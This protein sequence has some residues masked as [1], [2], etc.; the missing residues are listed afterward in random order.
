LL[1]GKTYDGKYWPG[2]K[3]ENS[4]IAYFVYHQYLTNDRMQYTT[5]GLERSISKNAIAVNPTEKLTDVWNIFIEMYSG[6]M[7]A[8]WTDFGMYYP[9]SFDPVYGFCEA[10]EG[11]SA[12]VSLKKFLSDFPNDYNTSYFK[13]YHIKNRFGL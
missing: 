12:F 13:T 11:A 5:V 4:L 1:N 3:Y 7:L 10:Q 2:L 6:I 9:Y 8:G